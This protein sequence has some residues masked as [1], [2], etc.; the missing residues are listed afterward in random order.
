M[1]IIAYTCPIAATDAMIIA[2]GSIVA[3][4]YQCTKKGIQWKF[5][6]LF[7]IVSQTCFGQ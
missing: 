2:F 3:R 6:E 7:S 4:N 5:E 1:V